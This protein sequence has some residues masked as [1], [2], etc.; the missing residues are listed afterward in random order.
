MSPSWAR[1]IAQEK[2]GAATEGRQDGTTEPKKDSST[3]SGE[4]E[5]ADG[6]PG[7]E[8]IRGKA[9]MPGTQAAFCAAAGGRRKSGRRDAD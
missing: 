3:S 6:A 8:Q 9:G 7:V 1:K 5:Q 4:Q 2:N